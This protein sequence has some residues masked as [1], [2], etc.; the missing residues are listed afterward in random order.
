MSDTENVI[1]R[2][3]LP[4][5]AGAIL[6]PNTGGDPMLTF[7]SIAAIVAGGLVIASFVGTRVA[8]KFLR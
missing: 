8:A 3:G 6:L 2:G 1:G 5:V 7:L 4:T